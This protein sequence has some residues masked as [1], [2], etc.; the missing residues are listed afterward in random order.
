MIADFDIKFSE[1]LCVLDACERP[2]ESITLLDIDPI[3]SLLRLLEIHVKCSLFPV[4][5]L[6]E[7]RC[8]ESDCKMRII[9]VLKNTV[10][11]TDQ[12]VELA[13]F[14]DFN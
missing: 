13:V 4:S 1:I 6:L 2:R 12:T 8:R 10:K 7:G 3:L 11:P 5:G 14:I 9:R